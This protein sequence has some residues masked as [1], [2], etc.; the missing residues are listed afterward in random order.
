MSSLD[1]IESVQWEP[2][3]EVNDQLG[4]FFGREK[5]LNVVQRVMVVNDERVLIPL[6]LDVGVE[7]PC[8]IQG[9]HK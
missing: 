8:V 6:N 5:P 3:V 7:F 1:I 4:E 9:R 2:A